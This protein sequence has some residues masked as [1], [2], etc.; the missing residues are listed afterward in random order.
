MEN[1]FSTICACKEIQRTTDLVRKVSGGNE[2]NCINFPSVVGEPLAGKVKANGAKGTVP[3]QLER[4]DTF[5]PCYHPCHKKPRIIRGKFCCKYFQ[6]FVVGHTTC[7]VNDS[8]I[9]F[10]L[11]H[12]LLP[13]NLQKYCQIQELLTPCP[14]SKRVQLCVPYQFMV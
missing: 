1:S 7:F 5:M 4:L 14:I 13:W 6:L 10:F 2:T 11:A 3:H 9:A 8:R 12:G